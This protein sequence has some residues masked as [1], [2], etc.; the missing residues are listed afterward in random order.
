M[1]EI[2]E[3]NEVHVTIYVDNFEPIHKI[4]AL[5]LGLYEKRF[6]VDRVIEQQNAA[7]LILFNKAWSAYPKLI[8]SLDFPNKFI[9]TLNVTKYSYDK[10]IKIS[11]Y[12]NDKFDLSEPSY[13][14]K[15][16]R[17]SEPPKD[18]K[19]LPLHVRLDLDISLRN[20]IDQKLIINTAN[21][22]YFA[23]QNENFLKLISQLCPSNMTTLY[24][25]MR[26]FSRLQSY[27]IDPDELDLPSQES[28]QK[29]I[30]LC[31]IF[32]NNSAITEFK[33]KN[34][35]TFLKTYYKEKMSIK[36]PQTTTIVD[37]LEVSD[38][39]KYPEH[40]V[41]N[42]LASFL[43]INNLMDSFELELSKQILVNA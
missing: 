9:K 37:T 10:T 34:L 15:F 11:S 19:T 7:K 5:I 30:D 25:N 31:K 8:F 23:E 6:A 12:I 21:K 41:I 39:D 17:G 1:I 36:F 40:P 33:F 16:L 18:S 26:T 14:T 35:I 20:G 13:V 28:K 4:I 3:K 22:F 24:I 2:R 27:K 38:F 29:F 42:Y 32:I 43:E